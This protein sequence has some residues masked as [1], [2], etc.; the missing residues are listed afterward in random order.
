MTIQKLED[1]PVAA[2]EAPLVRI[3]RRDVE[4][5]PEFA[6]TVHYIYCRINLGPDTPEARFK[7]RRTVESYP[8]DW[9]YPDDKDAERL[10]DEPE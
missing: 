2:P 6:G 1:T 10:W 4:R 8:A 9:P 7:G 3:P 5:E